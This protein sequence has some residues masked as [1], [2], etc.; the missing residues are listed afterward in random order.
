M[1]IS[2]L[3]KAQHTKRLIFSTLDQFILSG[4]NFFL[5]YLLLKLLTKSEYGIYNLVIPISLIFTALQNALINTPLM[6][7]YWNKKENER[8]LLV[9]SLLLVQKKI[10]LIIFFSTLTILFSYFLINSDIRTPIFYFSILLLITGILS[11]EFLRNYFFTIEKPQL[12]LENDLY[13]LLLI[14]LLIGI[15]Y[16][17]G[18]ININTTLIIIGTASFFSSIFKNKILLIHNNFSIA[19]K[20]FFECFQHGKWAL[21]GVIVTH[22][23]AYGYIYLIG[24]FFSTKD[25]GDISAVRLLFAPFTF[26][27]VGYSKIAIPR[28]AKLF[29]EKRTTRFFKEELVFSIFYSLVIVMYSIAILLIPQEFLL[30]I[31]KKEYLNSLEYLPYL[32]ISTIISIFGSTGSNGLQ[33]LK[34]FKGLSKINSLAM[35]IS[36]TFIMIL[37]FPYG[38][39]GALIANILAQFVNATGMWIM[40]YKLKNLK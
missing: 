3:L 30:I 32:S 6:V 40:F 27:T 16:S 29:N 8:T 1:N 15:T 7:E 38:I 10:F 39:K 23:Q 11:R 5:S 26:V 14:A 17:Y 25:I 33:A 2:N 22:L 4:I 18:V 20:H 24:L 35:I 9:S 13:Y 37:I 36:F 12:S 34:R 19:K 31:L 21:V 28:G